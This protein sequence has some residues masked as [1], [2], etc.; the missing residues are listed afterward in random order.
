VIVDIEYDDEKND[1][2]RKERLELANGAIK[3]ASLR[4][5]TLDPDL[6]KYRYQVTLIG[7]QGQI[8][9]GPS[10]ETERDIVGV[11]APAEEG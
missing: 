4:I 8:V 7:P 11:T 1:Y 6:V 9:R 5:A 2:H 3:P 10:L